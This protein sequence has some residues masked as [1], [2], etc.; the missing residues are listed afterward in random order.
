CV[1]FGQSRSSAASAADQ[2][3]I[4]SEMVSEVVGAGFSTV[5]R[6]PAVFIEKSGRLVPDITQQELDLIFQVA[7]QR[8]K[9]Q[10]RRTT[11]I[12]VEIHAVLESGHAE[13]ANP[14]RR[15]RDSFL[16]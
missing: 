2:A 10:A 14:L 7:G 6:C 8:Q 16:L 12:A 13:I 11:V 4:S 9:G 3:F 15:L 1:R 5:R